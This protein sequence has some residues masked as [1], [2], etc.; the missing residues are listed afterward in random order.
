MP[1]REPG[2]AQD[3]VGAHP[4]GAELANERLGD[5]VVRQRG[6]DSASPPSRSDRARDVR[7]R[8]GEDG[9]HLAGKRLDEPAE[10]GRLEPDHDFTEG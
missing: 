4:I 8:A 1:R 5:L 3:V 7:L 6:D 10:A 2:N 9:A